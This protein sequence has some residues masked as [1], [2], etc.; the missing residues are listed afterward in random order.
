MQSLMGFNRGMGA[1]HYPAIKHHLERYQRMA[2]EQVESPNWRKILKPYYAGESALAVIGNLSPDH[3]SRC[4]SNVPRP[5]TADLASFQTTHDHHW[6][7]IRK[8]F[9]QKIQRS[10]FHRP[11]MSTLSSHMSQMAVIWRN[12]SARYRVPGYHCL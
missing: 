9:H 7:Q 8:R 12:W 11:I 10:L 1:D 3:N 6:Y 2:V 5:Q 4:K